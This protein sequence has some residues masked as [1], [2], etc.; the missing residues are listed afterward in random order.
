MAKA[1]DDARQNAEVLARAAGVKLG[2]VRTLNGS[3]A[4]PPMPMYRRS[5]VMA[6]AV[7]AAPP[8]P[9][10]T[11]QTGDMKFSASVSAEYDLL[12]TGD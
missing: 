7:A 5:M 2:A 9:E 1:V 12:V 8:P 3:S 11:Y 10:E 6:D 4:A